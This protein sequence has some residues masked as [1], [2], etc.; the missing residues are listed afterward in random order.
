MYT[1]M[2]Y[3]VWIFPIVM[4]FLLVRRS[5][6]HVADARIPVG[7]DEDAPET[8][9]AAG[10]L[11]PLLA[12]DLGVTAADGQPA[13]WALAHE[14]QLLTIKLMTPTVAV[15]TWQAVPAATFGEELRCRWE[16]GASPASANLTIRDHGALHRDRSH[17]GTLSQP[18]AQAL[19]T[20][21]DG[22]PRPG[23]LVVE[24]EAGELRVM[25]AGTTVPELAERIAALAEPTRAM[26]AVVIATGRRLAPG[27]E[28]P[29]TPASAKPPTLPTTGP[30]GGS[31]LPSPFL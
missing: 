2:Q 21:F 3:T 7:A 22:V 15:L 29:V 26:H 14:D 8:R 25:V 17:D 30:N 16:R 28:R 5:K 18:L 19:Y 20:P 6:P 24:V 1:M 23:L 12:R 11:G 4:V 13:A 9:A 10:A 31:D 27:G